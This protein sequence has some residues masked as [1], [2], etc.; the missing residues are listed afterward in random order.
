MLVWVPLWCQTQD[1]VLFI[2]DGPF[3]MDS[4]LI[5]WLLKIGDGSTCN[6]NQPIEYLEA[7]SE[8]FP[9]FL[10]VSLNLVISALTLVSSGH[11]H[12]S[13]SISVSVSALLRNNS[14][15]LVHPFNKHN[16][17]PH[18]ILKHFHHPEK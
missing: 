9:P 2:Q 6:E 14:H 7:N 1:T 4:G 8:S 13:I 17:S 18:S 16:S 10:A 5:C 12:T 11:L 3:D 15:T